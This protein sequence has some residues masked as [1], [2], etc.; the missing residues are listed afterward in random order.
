[1]AHRSTSLYDARMII[2]LWAV[3][4]LL[5]ATLSAGVML[6]QERFKL[7]G[8][9]MAFWI[10]VATVCL[11]LPMVVM[12]G[13]PDNPYF[14]MF[15]AAQACLWMIC[16]VIFYN[17]IPKVGAGVV[18]RILPVSTILAFCLWFAVDHKLLSIYLETPWRS[19]G[20]FVMLCATSYFAM[21]MRKCSVS[22]EAVKLI[23]FVVAAAVIGPILAKLVTQN[24]D[25][26]Q[27]VFAYV[28][29]E[30][31]MMVSFWLVYYHVRK[32][33]L[34]DP[35]FARSSAKKGLAVG[36]LGA[37]TVV[38][39]VA[40][41]ALVDN[42]GLISAIKLTDTI[43]ILGVYRAIGRNDG[44]DVWAGLGIVACAAMV[45]AFK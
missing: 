1:M 33:V 26:Q 17:A 40:A 27:G 31:L 37:L 32:P 19:G 34:K 13:V 4:G 5:S 14:Y 6:G 39:S 30:A 41:I 16:D 23:W 21:R 11:M 24:A 3:F 15:L 7:D 2:P 35:L 36:V 44:S 20:V 38:S 45:I 9:V 8:F 29:F 28:F 10:K 25:F 18:S 42:P 43:I 12:N 22:I